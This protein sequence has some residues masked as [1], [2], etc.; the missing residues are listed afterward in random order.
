MKSVISSTASVI[1]I[2]RK[3][4]PAI[5]SLFAVSITHARSRWWKRSRCAADGAIRHA[6]ESAVAMSVM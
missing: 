3:T 1:A 6:V 4:S 2:A 5:V